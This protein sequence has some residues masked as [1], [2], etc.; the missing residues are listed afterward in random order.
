MILMMFQLKYWKLLFFYINTNILSNKKY[1]EAYN[2][3]FKLERNN[4]LH[5]N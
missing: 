3:K 5:T 2:K 4:I 1:E